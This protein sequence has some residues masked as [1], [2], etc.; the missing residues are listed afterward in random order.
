MKLECITYKI[1]EQHPPKLLHQHV[2][3][4][5]THATYDTERKGWALRDKSG[6]EINFVPNGTE[7]LV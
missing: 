6:T 1:S 2:S 4:P 3:S 5:I 7:W